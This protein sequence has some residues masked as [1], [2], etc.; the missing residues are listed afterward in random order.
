MIVAIDC[1]EIDLTKDEIEDK[2][3]DGQCIDDC[4]HCV[5]ESYTLEDYRAQQADIKHASGEDC[6]LKF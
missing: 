2:H 6:N 4:P 3:I 1:V 5:W